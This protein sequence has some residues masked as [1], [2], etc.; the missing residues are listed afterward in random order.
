MN[1][2]QVTDYIYILADQPILLSFDIDLLF[3]L[4]LTF[5]LIFDDYGTCLH[6]IIDP[7]CN[8]TK[9]ADQLGLLTSWVSESTIMLCLNMQFFH[10]I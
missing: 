9:F 10:E 1:I 5:D 8:E 2:S 7:L 6:L 4:T 3:S